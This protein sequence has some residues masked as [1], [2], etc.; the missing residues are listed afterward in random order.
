MTFE[1]FAQTQ[2]PAML[3]FATALT[4]QRAT[5]DD[6]AQEV[7]IRAMARWDRIGRV[8]RPDLYVRKMLLNEFLSSRRRSWRTIPAGDAVLAEAG[9]PDHATEYAEHEAMLAEISRLP[10]P[11]RA[12]LALRYYEDR[13]DAEI[14]ELL[15]WRPSTVRVYASRALA[16]LR[17]D[18]Q[19]KRPEE[20]SLA[21]HPG[22][23]L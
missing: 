21:R 17:V 14:A 9:T 19:L 13:S 1:E 5:A 15:G 16:A 22:G 2:L 20:A 23:E 4:G 12:V 3:A 10:R 6:L 8:D 7:L 18:R 11:Q